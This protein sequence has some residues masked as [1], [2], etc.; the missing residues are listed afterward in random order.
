MLPGP[1]ASLR[2]STSAEE[3]NPLRRSIHTVNSE[4]HFICHT[5]RSDPSPQIVIHLP[6]AE[7]GQTV[8]L[9]NRCGKNDIAERIHGVRVYVSENNRD[10]NKID[11]KLDNEQVYNHK[12]IPVLSESAPK[13][14]MLRRERQGDPIHIS[15]ITIGDLLEHD[16]NLIVEH[17]I[18]GLN[19][20]S[21][22]H[23]LRTNEQGWIYDRTRRYGLPTY[24]KPIWSSR[25]DID[26]GVYSV[27]ISALN[28]FS[29]ALIQIAHAVLFAHGIEARNV[30]V[31]ECKRTRDIF[32]KGNQFPCQ[33]L[34]VTIHIGNPVGRDNCLEGRFL[35]I[36]SSQTEFYKNLPSTYEAIRSFSYATNLYDQTETLGT[37]EMVIHIRSGDIFRPQGMIH[38]G[39]G[40]PPLSFYRK[41]VEHGKPRIV[42]LVYQDM[43]NPVIRPLKKWLRERSI[44]FT[45]PQKSSLRKDIKTLV[46]AQT[47]VAGRGTFIPGV[48]SL[49]ENLKTIYC[50][51]EALNLLG[52][53][54]VTYHVIKDR[55]RKYVDSIQRYNW[56]NSP[57][58]RELM[59]SYPDEELEL[60]SIART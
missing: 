24:I 27:Y 20:F 8:F 6:E 44:P 36:R 4:S 11:I 1:E 17:S 22:Q 47:L 19:R 43:H 51:D 13:Y 33:E 3:S 30:F 7:K 2:E 14:I 56:R 38:P 21:R 18:P 48:V 53:Q 5:C 16:Y 15:Q 28:R 50:F 60:Q 26:H 23:N 42:H 49:G 10:W 55:S 29:N 34:E 39:Y 37:D 58:Q 35:H 32:P 9:Y 57:E 59:I 40:Q 41:A 46:S 31:P 25:F 45:K 52:L 12:P 54:G